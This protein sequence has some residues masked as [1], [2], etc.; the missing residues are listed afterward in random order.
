MRR[1]ALLCLV[2]FLITAAV[3]AASPV[4]GRP[5][6]A[7]WLGAARRSHESAHRR[8]HAKPHS[9]VSHTLRG[10]VASA[11]SVEVL[12]GDET[13]E[14]GRGEAVAAQAEAFPFINKTNGSASS[15]D[16]YLRSPNQATRLVAGLYVDNNGRPGALA[17][18]GSLASLKGGAWNLVPIHSTVVTPRK[19]WL[20]VVGEGGTLRFRDRADGPCT[21]EDSSRAHLSTLPSSWNVGATSESC[22]I[23]AY[24]EGSLTQ[25]A[26]PAITLP[27]LNTGAPTISGSAIDSDTLTS[28]DGSWADSPTSYTYQWQD[29]TTGSLGL[30]CS[31]IAGAT[32]SSY[33]LT[34]SDVGDDVRAVVTAAN[35]AGSTSAP[36]AETSAVTLPPPPANT[37]APVVSG[38]PVQG[39]TLST[40]NGTWSNNP[41]SYSYAWEDCNSSGGSC[42]AI[43]SAA[44]NSYT[45]T[46]SDVGHTIRS[47]VTATNDGGSNAA[48]S[49]QT[50]VV[51]VVPPSN[52]AVP[53]ISG[54]EVQ[55]QTLTTSN[56]TWSGNPTGY[57][58]AWQ[59]CDSSGNNCT[60]IANVTANTYAL[61]SPDVGH[62]IRSVVTATNSGGSATATS[63]QTAV[64]A[65]TA[66]TNA[67]LPV[68]SGQ[69]VQG[70]AL[71][72]TNGSWRNNPTAYAYQWQDC[73]S[74]GASCANVSN[75]TGS[76]YSLA[77]G[78]VGHTLR[79]VV[80]ASNAS[81]SAS[82]TSAQTGVVTSS[83]GGGSAPS[84]TAL[85]SVT[86]TA[87]QGDT[88]STSNGSWNGS[89]TSFTYA[90]ED[91]DS[92]GANCSAIGGATSS[93]YTLASADV[94]HTVRAVVSAHNASGAAPASSAQ[95]AV[96]S[97]AS[98]TS[99]EAPVNTVL[100]AITDST[101]S[102]R[103]AY[104]DVLTATNGT[105]TVNGV[106]TSCG[107]AS[108]MVC[109]YQWQDCPPA[110]GSCTNI[111]TGDCLVLC[112]STYRVQASDEGYDIRV[113]VT[114][115]AAS[116]G[117][118]YSTDATSAGV[119]G[120]TGAGAASCNYNVG[121]ASALNT[122]YQSASPGQTICLA[123]GTYSWTATATRSSGAP[124]LI[125]PAPGASV[126]F[127]Q[128]TANPASYVTIAGP[129]TMQGATLEGE[130]SNLTIFNTSQTGQIEP[131]VD[132]FTSSSNVNIDNNSWT[133]T[134]QC[135][136]GG[137]IYID[138]NNTNP[139]T[140]IG[141]TI[142]NNYFDGG[143]TED[144]LLSGGGGTTIIGNDFYAEDNKLDETIHSDT[145]QELDWGND[146]IKD[147]WFHD[148]IDVPSCGWAEWDGGEK[149]VIENNVIS[150]A[151]GVTGSDGCAG[152]Y[153]PALMDDGF[154]N[155]A[156]GSTV[157]HNVI[158]P[159]YLENGTTRGGNIDLGGKTSEG[160]GAGTQI[161]NNTYDHIS[162]GDG[163]EDA[164]FTTG[165]NLCATS[166][167]TT[168]DQGSRA[169]DIVGS[170]SWVGGSAPSSFTGFAL[171]QGSQG[172]GDASDGTNIGIEL[173]TGYS[174]PR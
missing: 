70:D 75:A 127:S 60:D 92:S 69:T 45:L 120:G 46:S 131:M 40:S 103:Y 25:A 140:P 65:S 104:A 174:Y 167:T 11:A 53:T 31:D 150:H 107:A 143:C 169:G 119:G 35:S 172:I 39:Q 98:G 61:A 72:T 102:G 141:T 22:P 136:S 1:L 29:C 56:G 34:K 80:T 81:G 49:T 158:E 173:P 85:P 10:P 163:G 9:G 154:G 28:S 33:T 64:V 161:L 144:I 100:P 37:A 18:V 77:A 128:F 30:V 86:G 91:C 171:A 27:P 155:A 7:K 12:F 79:V 138:W 123:S 148:Q 126:T 95:T 111:T 159:G 110:G 87:T 52:T 76:S 26:D 8:R 66:P 78:D 6:A 170:P 156:D 106:T 105:W 16:V 147:N 121:S 68:I 82:A 88:L 117:V 130:T 90:W 152:E 168:G 122:D 58:Y 157:S 55:G 51:T 134:S 137:R 129:L 99:G 32:G 54:S 146:V 83:G 62:T 59:D 57:S 162:N 101:Q 89:P 164:T 5:A 41:K 145:I 15:I 149:N 160:A 20:A 3:A 94:G 112:Q 17:A 153:G 63:A 71:S 97:S 116:G 124:V 142:S 44:A 166:C 21:S 36:S 48:D 38:A 47:I 125:Q 108:G 96:V 151:G 4:L 43:G 132:D 74:S 2:G 139:H 13:I 14:S 165:Y 73:N 67:A 84:N 115:G 135:G 114:A 24:V 93:G 50:A 109:A 133:N 118:G 113:I 23:S 42:T 19:Y